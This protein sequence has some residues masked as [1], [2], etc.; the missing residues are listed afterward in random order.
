MVLV[1]TQK[2]IYIEDKLLIK[3]SCKS[4]QMS[5]IKNLYFSDILITIKVEPLFNEIVNLAKMFILLKIYI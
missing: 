4:M 1:V 5:F 2:Y 3:P